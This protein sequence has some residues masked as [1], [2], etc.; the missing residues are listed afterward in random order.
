MLY[1]KVILRLKGVFMD[2]IYIG[3]ALI[4]GIVIG[5]LFLDVDSISNLWAKKEEEIDDKHEEERK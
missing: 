3:V 2:L 1:Y 5:A 4:V